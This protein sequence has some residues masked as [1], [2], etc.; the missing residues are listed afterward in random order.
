MHSNKKDILVD[1]QP[2]GNCGFNAFILG[3]ISIIEQ[4]KLN[5]DVLESFLNTFFADNPSLI[6][7]NELPIEAFKRFL[8]ANPDKLR[9]QLLLAPTLRKYSTNLLKLSNEVKQSLRQAFLAALREY[10][11][12]KYKIKSFETGFEG[13]DIFIRIPKIKQFFET[14]TQNESFISMANRDDLDIILDNYQDKIVSFWD[15][16][17]FDIY[18]AYV[19]QNGTWVGDIELG[20]LAREFQV[21]LSV[22]R[23]TAIYQLV[24]EFHQGTIRLGNNDATHWDCYLPFDH[25][26]AYAKFNI[27]D[28]PEY[29]SELVENIAINTICDEVEEL[30]NLKDETNEKQIIIK[31]LQRICWACQEISW[32]TKYSGKF[33]TY[34]PDDS[35]WYHL[36]TLSRLLTNTDKHELVLSEFTSLLLALENF[37]EA[38]KL[39]QEVKP[40]K[41]EK[42]KFQTQSL[43]KFTFN[44]ILEEQDAYFL[45]E[46]EEILKQL[47]IIKFDDDQTNAINGLALFYFIIAAGELAKRLSKDTLK[48]LSILEKLSYIRDKTTHASFLHQL[49]KNP[50]GLIMIWAHLIY[51]SGALRNGDDDELLCNKEYPIMQLYELCQSSNMLTA[52]KIIEIIKK[53]LSPNK[54][55]KLNT[56]TTPKLTFEMLLALIEIPLD[57]YN[58]I[59]MCNSDNEGLEPF[60]SSMKE[61]LITQRNT[62]INE[63]FQNHSSLRDQVITHFNKRSTINA[64]AQKKLIQ[65]FIIKKQQAKDVFN[66]AELRADLGKLFEELR[67]RTETYPKLINTINNATSSTDLITLVKENTCL[68]NFD[69]NQFDLNKDDTTSLNAVINNCA[70]KFNI[71]NPNLNKL[72]EQFK[73]LKT[74][75]ENLNTD[76]P[77]SHEKVNKFLLDQM[78][79]LLKLDENEKKLAESLYHTLRL[80]NKNEFKDLLAHF[81]LNVEELDELIYEDTAYKNI[82]KDRVD[83]KINYEKEPET[84]A[85]KLIK[86][87]KSLERIKDFVIRIAGDKKDYSKLDTIF[88]SSS[89]YY[90]GAKKLLMDMGEIITPIKSNPYFTAHTFENISAQQLFLFTLFRNQLAHR[91]QEVTASYVK[92]FFIKWITLSPAEL[93]LHTSNIK[94]KEYKG[95]NISGSRF[96]NRVIVEPEIIKERLFIETMALIH[97]FD[98]NVKVFGVNLGHRVGVQSPLNLLVGYTNDNQADEQL[99]ELTWQLSRHFGCIVNV[100]TKNQLKKQIGLTI[101][102]GQYNEIINSAETILTLEHDA[103]KREL[104]NSEQQ[105]AQITTPRGIEKNVSRSI[106]RGQLRQAQSLTLNIDDRYLSSLRESRE[107]MLSNARVQKTIRDKATKYSS[108]LKNFANSLQQTGFKSELLTLTKQELEVN[109]QLDDYFITHW[110]E[111]TR[112]HKDANRFQFRDWVKRNENNIHSIIKN[113][114]LKQEAFDFWEAQGHFFELNSS[115]MTPYTNCL[116]YFEEINNLAII[117]LLLNDSLSEEQLFRLIYEDFIK[118]FLDPYENAW[119]EVLFRQPSLIYLGNGNFDYTFTIEKY[120]K[121]SFAVEVML[122]VSK[123]YGSTQKILTSTIIDKCIQKIESLK[124]GQQKEATSNDIITID[125]MENHQGKIYNGRVQLIDSVM[126][127]FQHQKFHNLTDL[128]KRYDMLPNQYPDFDND[129]QALT[130]YKVLQTIIKQLTNIE[131]TILHYK[132]LIKRG[133]QYISYHVQRN[134]VTETELTEYYQV[135]KHKEIKK[136][137][138]Y[139]ISVLL[140]NLVTCNFILN[141]QEELQQSNLLPQIFDELTEIIYDSI[142]GSRL[143]LSEKELQNHKEKFR[144]WIGQQLSENNN[145]SEEEAGLDRYQVFQ[146]Q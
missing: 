13:D 92:W 115:L 88:N 33:K 68:N 83:S 15:E 102:Q 141:R 95:F 121:D 72:R 53:A 9:R 144:K 82:Y 117:D 42:S 46:I 73:V 61:Y 110:D 81:N 5:T 71:S 118:R 6:S 99:H 40:K 29:A 60:K 80:K 14:L 124:R 1:A 37:A 84:D 140:S 66:T 85:K 119:Q 145:T 136:E 120:V 133:K 89:P 31:R 58:S 76:S 35:I 104:L 94:S 18:I 96:E 24:E 34:F 11:A 25:A 49:L 22:R 3:L 139:L 106:T 10:I 79:W 100:T 19:E 17:G 70:E 75:I 54:T 65:T 90:Y 55:E 44:W 28:M 32:Q 50:D 30:K 111:I 20:V 39:C 135:K 143:N 112:F 128:L 107:Q 98:E 105:V 93:S 4:G 47:E 63:V 69:Y 125:T 116:M 109:S 51:I 62:I 131:L 21:N 127:S 138:R 57:D 16:E 123:Q 23:G 132:K 103:K 78:S 36:E 134:A 26:T 122:A 137:L 113:E 101:S 12:T 142:K 38:L 2:N 97:G 77:Q 27:I 126:Y 8:H 91:P 45:N 52:D 146:P 74:F 87:I 43:P 59:M 7:Q 114:K 86:L 108:T 64:N 48:H 67:L 130:D 56:L 129:N 41:D